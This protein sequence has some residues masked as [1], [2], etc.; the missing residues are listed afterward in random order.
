MGRGRMAFLRLNGCL[1][2]KSGTDAGRAELLGVV[3]PFNHVPFSASDGGCEGGLEIEDSQPF[4]PSS[5]FRPL[6]IFSNFGS[7]LKR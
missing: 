2:E 7:A 3:V 5:N 6:Q 4:Q 1:G